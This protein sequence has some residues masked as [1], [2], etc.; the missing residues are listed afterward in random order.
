MKIFKKD[1]TKKQIYPP[2]AA[3]IKVPLNYVFSESMQYRT[4][5]MFLILMNLMFQ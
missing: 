1:K 3:V 4:L 2:P 5:M